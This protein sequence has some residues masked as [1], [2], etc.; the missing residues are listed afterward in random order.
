MDPNVSCLGKKKKNTKTKTQKALNP[1]F[2]SV[3]K[4]VIKLLL[5]AGYSEF[6]P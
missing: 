5:Q 1:L 2:F 3:L 6:R 4:V